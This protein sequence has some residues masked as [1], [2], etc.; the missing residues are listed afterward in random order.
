MIL[1]KVK[2]AGVTYKVK[3]Q[4]VVLNDDGHKLHGQCNYQQLIISLG[5]G[6]PRQKSEQTFFH[7]VLHAISE[8]YNVNLTEDQ[9]I[10]L[11][12]GIYQVYQDNYKGRKLL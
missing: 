9:V 4:E 5:K 3:E 11:T 6:F 8:E 10:Q 7:E 12:T 2:V 1:Q